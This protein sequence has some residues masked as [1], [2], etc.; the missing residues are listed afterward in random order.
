MC[1]RARA[2]QVCASSNDQGIFDIT[3]LLP[4][5]YEL[6]VQAPGFSPLTQ[7]LRLEVGQHMALNLTLKVASVKDVV[8]VGDIAP[9]LHS[10]DSSVGEV[11]EPVA[12][13]DLPLNGRMLVVCRQRSTW[14]SSRLWPDRTCEVPV[15]RRILQCAQSH[16]PGHTR[17]FREHATIRHITQSTTPGKEIQL[18]ARLSF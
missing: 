1:D 15:S 4:G 7:S 11:I 16:E 14:P 10:S 17:P 2:K 9:A 13:H 6:K 3:G 18:S 5:D 12:V 8:E